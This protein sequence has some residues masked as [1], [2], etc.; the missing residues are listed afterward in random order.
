MTCWRT[1]EKVRS[2]ADEHLN[3][4]AF[5]FTHKPKEHVLGADVVVPELQRLAQ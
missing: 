4:D 2:Q 5:A 3:S 1:R